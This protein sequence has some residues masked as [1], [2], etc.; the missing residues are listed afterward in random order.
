[1][2]KGLCIFGMVG[3]GLLLLVFGLD[4]ALGMPFGR[5]SMIMDLGFIVAAAGLFAAS[6]MTLREIP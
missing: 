6:F 5:I 1:M 4:L 3:A 2:G